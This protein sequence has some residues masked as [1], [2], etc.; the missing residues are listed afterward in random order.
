MGDTYVKVFNDFVTH[1]P[2]SNF[3]FIEEKKFYIINH[4]T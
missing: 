3:S 2:I 1:F 4:S